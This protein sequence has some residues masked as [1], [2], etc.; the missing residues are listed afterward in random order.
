[1]H[2]AGGRQ[3]Y[4]RR[5]PRT[6]ARVRARWP[7]GGV[8]I[9]GWFHGFVLCWPNTMR[10]DHKRGVL[11][12][13]V[14]LRPNVQPQL[15]SHCVDRSFDP[16]KRPHHCLQLG[17]VRP[18]GS[19]PRLRDHPCLLYRS[20]VYMSTEKN[21]QTTLRPCVVGVVCACVERCPRSLGRYHSGGAAGCRGTSWCSFGLGSGEASFRARRGRWRGPARAS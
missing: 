2:G 13:S 20:Q 17:L 6:L 11:P 10:A 19:H 12:A 21:T 3:A 4:A 18:L 8:S 5:F 15:A 14:S 16:G 9:P 7:G 1:M